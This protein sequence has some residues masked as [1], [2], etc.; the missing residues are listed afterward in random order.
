MA[1]ILDFRFYVHFLKTICKVVHLGYVYVEIISTAQ[2]FTVRHVPQ[3]LLAPW[4]YF[5]NYVIF[6]DFGSPLGFVHQKLIMLLTKALVDPISSNSEEPTDA[7]GKKAV[8]IGDSGG[9]PAY[10]N[11]SDRRVKKS[12]S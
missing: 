9:Y 3:I 7:M 5:W 12:K 4:I 2:P 11:R 6:Y 10:P 8:R 1:A